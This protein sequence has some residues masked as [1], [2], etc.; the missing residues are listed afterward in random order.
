MK[1]NP[2]R[3]LHLNCGLKP[4]TTSAEMA[5][6]L[7]GRA[8]KLPAALGIALR[9][10]PVVSKSSWVSQLISWVSAP[11]GITMQVDKDALAAASKVYDQIS[12]LMSES[13]DNNLK[14]VTDKY[15]DVLVEAAPGKEP[16][17]IIGTSF[18]AVF[19]SRRCSPCDAVVLFNLFFLP[20]LFLTPYYVC[21]KMQMRLTS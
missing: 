16:V 13:K 15:T 4:V 1:E 7:R 19:S 2:E 14:Y 5:Q 17:F 10:I 18:F 20:P 6:A 11:W 3:F 8:S 12:D 9:N 21:F